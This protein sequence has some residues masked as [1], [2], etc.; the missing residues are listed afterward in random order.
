MHS[1]FFRAQTQGVPARRA[2]AREG[3][4]ASGPITIPTYY[5]YYYYR[6]HSHYHYY[7]YYY[8]YYHHYCYYYYYCYYSHSYYRPPRG[9]R[10]PEDA[11]C[12]FPEYIRLMRP[13]Q[14]G[15]LHFWC[16]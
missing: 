5:Y 7:Y 14:L 11:A 10:D 12:D 3:R 1:V 15:L 16:S 13:L 8:D 6:S 2:R 9:A 4:L